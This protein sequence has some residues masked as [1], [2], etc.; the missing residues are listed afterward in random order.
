MS[1]LVPIKVKKVGFQIQNEIEQLI[2]E[3]NPKEL[4]KKGG[5]V[6]AIKKILQSILNIKAKYLTLFY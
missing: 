2:N 5:L 1:E 3:N 6:I 4:L